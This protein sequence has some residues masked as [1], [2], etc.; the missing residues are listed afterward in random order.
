MQRHSNPP[1][2]LSRPR[3]TVFSLVT[4]LAAGAV[5]VV[6]AGDASAGRVR[7]QVELLQRDVGTLQERL[8]RIEGQQQAILES[9]AEIRQATGLNDPGR[10]TPA[11]LAARLGA[12]EQDVRV[13]FEQQGETGA[14]LSMVSDR[15][16]E[17]YRHREVERRRPLL[18]PEAFEHGGEGEPASTWDE[19]ATP[20]GQR[21]TAESGE[22][23]GFDPPDALPG[24]GPETASGAGRGAGPPPGRPLLDPREVYDV[25]RADYARG[26]YDLAIAGFEEFLDL[27]PESDLADN[28]RYWIGESYHAEGRHAEALAAFSDVRRT[29]PVSE[30]VPDAE[31][32]RGLTLLEL[33]RTADGI[34]ALQGVRDGWPESNAAR[35]A[36]QKLRGLGLL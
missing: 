6:I 11:D 15:I 31:Y 34:L 18:P 22:I 28:A 36:G 9:L 17:I 27:F 13:V 35:L 1:H 30:K 32:K 7:D 23:V 2:E 24:D 10:A 8:L 19:S 29:W 12:L 4:T 5:L 33:N 16:D 14:R 25:A 3:L 26:T 20:L 21:M